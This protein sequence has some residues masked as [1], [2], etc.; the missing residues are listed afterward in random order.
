MANT[1]CWLFAD[2]EPSEE[3]WVKMP[4]KRAGG[5]FAEDLWR[6]A[7]FIRFRSGEAIALFPRFTTR[8][9]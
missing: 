9:I 6:G 5:D 7:F 4:L 3:L 8:A 1:R 2:L